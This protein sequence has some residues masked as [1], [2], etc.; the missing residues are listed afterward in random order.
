MKHL[1]EAVQI[2]GAFV[3]VIVGAG[4]ASGQEIMRFFTSFGINGLVGAVISSALFVF[5]SMALSSLSKHCG[6]GSHKEVIQ[7]MG[8]A[9]S[10]QGYRPDD[11]LLHVRNRGGDVLGGW[12][13]AGAIVWPTSVVGSVFTMVAT[14]LIV[15]LD[16]RQVIAISVVGRYLGRIIVGPVDAGDSWW[17]VCP[18]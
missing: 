18:G 17:H 5:L 8:G 11:H 6:G 7:L 1:K 14:I 15:C 9:I 4:F 2:G 12:C 10:G 3:G 16:V 13:L